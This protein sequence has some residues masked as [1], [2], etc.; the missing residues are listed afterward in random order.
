MQNHRHLGIVV[1]A[2]HRIA[3]KCAKRI[4]EIL[5]LSNTMAAIAPDSFLDTSYELQ[6]L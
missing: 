4:G 6:S 3:R 1:N 2:P 5:G